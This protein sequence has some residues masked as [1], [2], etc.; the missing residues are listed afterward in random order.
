MFEN[1]HNINLKPDQ[2]KKTN[3]KRMINENYRAGKE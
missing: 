1:I 3:D 2:A